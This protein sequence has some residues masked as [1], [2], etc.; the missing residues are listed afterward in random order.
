[1]ISD[2]SN[3]SDSHERQEMSR[4]EVEADQSALG[5]RVES[6]VLRQVKSLSPLMLFICVPTLLLIASTV[7]VN[8]KTDLPIRYFFIDPVAEFNAPMYIGLLSNF[9]VLLW[10]SAASVC[11]FSGVMLFHQE[12][13]REV[14]L[15]LIGSGLITSL[16]MFD[17]LY[18]LHEEVFPDHLFVPQPLVFVAYAVLIIAYFVRFRKMIWNTDFA[19]VSCIVFLC[20]LGFSGFVCHARR[21]LHHGEHLGS[22]PDRRRV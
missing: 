4:A 19:S 17:D 8:L 18:L 3:R 13:Q 12:K 2:S 14:S 16:L 9:G 11:L 1:M 10:C 21:V 22:P 20:Q 15:F 5:A 7:V 6:E